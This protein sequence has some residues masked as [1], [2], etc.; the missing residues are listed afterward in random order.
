MGVLDFTRNEADW[1]FNNF[2]EYLIS[3]AMIDVFLDLIQE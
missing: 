3:L 1:A 2:D